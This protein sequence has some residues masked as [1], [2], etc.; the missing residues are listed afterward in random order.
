L[1][2]PDGLLE[3]GQIRRAHGVRGDVLVELASD[4]PERVAAGARWFARDRWLTV[5]SARPH[6][7]RWLVS[8]AELDDRTAAQH[9]T[10]AP[11]YAEPLDDP[12]AMFVHELIGADVVE[13]SGR[14]RGRCVAVVA[15]PAADLLE[16]ESGALVP[17]VFVT[18]S[19]PRT[20]V[21]DPPIGLFDDEDGG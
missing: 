7:Q 17:V 10:N 5:V 6:Q 15:N 18:E 2:R 1:V 20:I 21:I 3:I 16:L 13:A 12:D 8:L 4:R 19:R 9:F 14:R 11:V